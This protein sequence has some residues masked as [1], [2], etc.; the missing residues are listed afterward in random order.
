MY[1]MHIL[2]ELS[3]SA[4]LRLGKCEIVHENQRP[5]VFFFFRFNIAQ[6]SLKLTM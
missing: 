6:A 3:L 5:E 2:G 4:S 1:N